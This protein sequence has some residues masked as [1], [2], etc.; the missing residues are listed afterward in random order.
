[1]LFN[2]FMTRDWETFQHLRRRHSRSFSTQIPRQMSF[3]Y[4]YHCIL[5]RAHYGDI[6]VFAYIW[7]LCCD[8]LPMLNARKAVFVFN[9]L[10]IIVATLSIFLYLISGFRLGLCSWF[11]YTVAKDPTAVEFALCLLARGAVR[12]GCIVWIRVLANVRWLF[13]YILIN[14][15]HL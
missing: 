2:G 11:S 15:C 8:Q 1:M 9:V 6:D 14:G 4:R 12:F 10:P 13:F 7:C 3:H 5:N